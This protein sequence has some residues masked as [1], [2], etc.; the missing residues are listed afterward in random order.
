M[1]HHSHAQLVLL[2]MLLIKLN[3]LI[4]QPVLQDLLVKKVQELVLRRKLNVL[5]VIIVLQEQNI[6]TNTLVQ[7]VNIV[8]KL[9]TQHQLH[10]QL[11]LKDIIV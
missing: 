6:L 3:P 8:L 4:V 1:V 9:I 2:L 11:V 5:Q 7:L 10:A